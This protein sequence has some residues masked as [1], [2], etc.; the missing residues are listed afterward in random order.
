MKRV[1]VVLICLCLSVVSS[2]CGGSKNKDT[3]SQVQSSGSGAD[4]QSDDYALK[5][6]L[7][8]SQYKTQ[9]D[10]IQKIISTFDA[11]DTWW[12]NFAS[13]YQNIQ[14]ITDT[15]VT[16]EASV[17]SEYKDD[18]NSI[19]DVT[20]KYAD[21]LNSIS[22][23]EGKSADEQTSI[24]SEAGKE[25]NRANVEWGSIPASLNSSS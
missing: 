2:G 7:F 1:L 23:A 15:F 22:Q 14:D 25:M 8:V 5:R 10:N 21:A 12:G 6:D 19:K 13:N 20:A 17:K 9:I 4:K 24:I 18:F 16:N 11:S 3:S